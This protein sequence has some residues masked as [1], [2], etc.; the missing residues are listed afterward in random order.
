MKKSASTSVFDCLQD[1]VCDLLKDFPE[2][3]RGQNARN[4]NLATKFPRIE[5]KFGQRS[6]CL[7]M[8]NAYNNLPILARQFG[9][10]Y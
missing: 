5:A 9:R 1:N 6:F 10:I 8:T 2:K 4:N 7:S 3:R